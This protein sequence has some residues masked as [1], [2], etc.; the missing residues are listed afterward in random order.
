LLAG[1]R[2]FVAAVDIQSGRMRWR[3]RICDVPQ[4]QPP[5]TTMVQL[6]ISGSD[7]FMVCGCGVLANLDAGSGNLRWIRRYQ[8]SVDDVNPEG[9]NAQFFGRMNQDWQRYTLQGWRHDLAV[10]WGNWVIVAASDTNFLAGYRRSDGQLVW[11]APR[12]DVL[13][14]TVDQWLGVHD[15]I[16][17]A[18]GSRGLIAYELAAEGRLYGTPIR[19]EPGLSGRGIITSQGILLPMQDHLELYDLKSLAKIKEIPVRMPGEMPIGSLLSD[20]QRLWVAAMNRLIALEP[21]AEVTT[22]WHVKSTEELNIE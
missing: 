15:G 17:Y 7:V 19:L 14:C 6:A 4:L 1:G 21:S 10:T 20:G 8:R 9:P 13:G 5:S 16:V 2:F 12:A 3:R 18:V 11:R 22:P